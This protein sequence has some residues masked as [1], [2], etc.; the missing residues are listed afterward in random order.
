MR[1]IS[2]LIVVAAFALAGCRDV[3]SPPAVVPAD[4]A[5]VPLPAPDT[6][7]HFTADS[8]SMWDISVFAPGPH[9]PVPDGELFHVLYHLGPAGL[10]DRYGIAIADTMPRVVY[11]YRLNS[12][13]VVICHRWLIVQRGGTA[14]LW[15]PTT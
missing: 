6:M 9:S 13:G 5:I 8:T 11:G 12:R 3:V 15:C 10:H 2:A 7:I 14:A 4:T 1:S